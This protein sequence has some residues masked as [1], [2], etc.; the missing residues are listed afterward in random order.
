MMASSAG[1]CYLFYPVLYVVYGDFE[2]I[3]LYIE[4]S[5]YI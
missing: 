1:T 4:I 3:Y 5:L 2:E